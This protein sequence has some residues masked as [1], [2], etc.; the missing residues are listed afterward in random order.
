MITAM[1]AGTNNLMR[2]LRLVLIGRDDYGHTIFW[3]RKREISRFI[4]PDVRVLQVDPGRA[5]E[6][7]RKKLCFIGELHGIKRCKIGIVRPECTVL[8]IEE[9]DVH[10]L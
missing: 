1:N 9:K 8:F 3:Y 6:T 2:R 10:D 5:G 4:E 7:A